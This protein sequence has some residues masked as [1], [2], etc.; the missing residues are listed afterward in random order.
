MREGL[1]AY[2]V[3]HGLGMGEC[4]V[5]QHPAEDAAGELELCG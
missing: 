1:T 2:P 3:V 5:Q 4:A